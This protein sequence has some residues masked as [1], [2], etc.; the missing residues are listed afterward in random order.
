MGK[1]RVRS[2]AV[3][4]WALA[5]I[6]T[7]QVLTGG[8]IRAIDPRGERLGFD[9]LWVQLLT[10][11]WA[12][13]A[14]LLVAAVMGIVSV[15]RARDALPERTLQAWSHGIRAVIFV[16]SAGGFG[17]VLAL[18][19]DELEGHIFW[20]AAPWAA[21][22]LAVLAG[23]FIVNCLLSWT[24]QRIEERRRWYPENIDE[25][26]E[27]FRFYAKDRG[28]VWPGVRDALHG[29]IL[30][31]LLA[32]GWALRP[33]A[34]GQLGVIVVSIIGVALLGL[35]AL[36]ALH[37]DTKEKEVGDA[38]RERI[39][40]VRAFG[41]QIR[42]EVVSVD[43]VDWSVPST[44]S[45]VVCFEITCRYETQD[46]EYRFS[47]RILSEVVDAPIVGGTVLVW[48]LGDA[49]EDRYMEPDPDS[50]RDPDATANYPRPA[51]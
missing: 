9:P 39:G 26:P 38:V 12:G 28:A 29:G 16:L 22:A 41:E 20:D 47:D 4:W 27:P 1:T 49:D 10:A 8:V 46:A 25:V 44:L 14:L 35:L 34:T 17:F 15:V 50:I 30:G 45:D 5:G 6:G 24:V 7:T 37:T 11:T 19:W 42:A 31:A 36:A 33:G 48:H 3:V 13:L 2:T 40:R 18:G 51:P 21:G 23:I 32:I 43:A